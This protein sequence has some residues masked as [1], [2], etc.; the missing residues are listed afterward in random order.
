MFWLFAKQ[1]EHAILFILN[2]FI[3]VKLPQS[4]P[5]SSAPSSFN[6]HPKLSVPKKTFVSTGLTPSEQLRERP[7]KEENDTCT[8]CAAGV[9]KP[10]LLAEMV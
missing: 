5:S 4:R 1:M 10:R 7:E 2:I 9:T 3:Q 6:L 8:V